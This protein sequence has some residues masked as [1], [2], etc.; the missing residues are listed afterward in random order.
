MERDTHRTFRKIHG[1]VEA[2][3][4]EIKRI[5]KHL[6][7]KEQRQTKFHLRF[8]TP[9]NV[10]KNANTGIVDLRLTPRRE[11]DTSSAY[12]AVSYTWNQSSRLEK[13]PF[14]D[15]P[16]YRIWTSSHKWR[17]PRCPPIVLHRALN[18]A[19]RR[20]EKPLLWIDQE[21]IIQK[22]PADVEWHLQRMHKV[23]SMSAYTIALLS[24]VVN[25]QSLLQEM[26]RFNQRLYAETYFREEGKS[27]R[28]LELL[29]LLQWMAK[30]AW[31]ERTWTFQERCSAKNLF[32][33]LPISASLKVS[34]VSG[35]TKE[36]DN[37]STVATVNGVND[38]PIKTPNTLLPQNVSIAA[39]QF[40]DI[41]N[42]LDDIAGNYR[43]SCSIHH[44][45]T[46]DVQRLITRY[47][48]ASKS[49]SIQ[50]TVGSPFI[51]DVFRI[52]QECN[53]SIVADRLAILAN[54]CGFKKQ[55]S[56]RDVNRQKISFSTCVLVL[57]HHNTNLLSAGGEKLPV[58]RLAKEAMGLKISDVMR[59]LMI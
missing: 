47:F 8:L 30:D 56:S 14:T 9:F 42:A 40:Q 5:E 33:V 23:Y 22:D 32:Y 36:E 58:S 26:K 38:A 1:S 54:V 27:C 2:M 6:V 13:D 7:V 15:M 52:M 45:D 19:K 10:A 25:S 55:L 53:N 43:C 49:S 51:Q 4:S 11:L 21:C 3:T 59:T 34:V 57:L 41:R 46:S 17:S 18:F 12:V 48:I 31:F 37:A 44:G 50:N 35:A 24:R 28:L 29:R 20:L 39:S 16:R